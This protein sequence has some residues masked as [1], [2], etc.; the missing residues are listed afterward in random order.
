L[1]PDGKVVT[2]G[3]YSV[4]KLVSMALPGYPRSPKGWYGL[5][6][7]EKWEFRDVVGRG[8]RSGSLREFRPPPEVLALIEQ[9]QRGEL[10]PPPEK[11]APAH[12]ERLQG[13]PVHY[14]VS[15]AS[16]QP[17]GQAGID[18]ALLRLCLGA[19]AYIY[20]E[21]F[22]AEPPALQ[23]EYAADL[24]NQL[25]RLA[26]AHPAGL[27]SGLNAFTRL[28]MRGLADQLRLLVQMA[29]VRPYPLR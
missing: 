8:G 4:A 10:R 27:K 23:L 6:D 16:P 17:E 9:H 24:Y 22:A 3:Y 15:E 28:E 12:Q 25:V 13:S 21:S 14:R 19:L 7:R 2:C 26:A 11:P 20:G 1:L 5:V 18:T 29:S